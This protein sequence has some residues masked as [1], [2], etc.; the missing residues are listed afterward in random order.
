MAR[1]ILRARG[2]EGEKGVVDLSVLLEEMLK[3][4]LV[5]RDK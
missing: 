4:L 5:K 2:P 1:Y 3:E